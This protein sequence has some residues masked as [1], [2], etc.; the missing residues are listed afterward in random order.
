[1]WRELADG[2]AETWSYTGT[3]SNPVVTH[4]RGAGSRT[5][6][7]KGSQVQHTYNRTGHEVAHMESE[8]DGATQVTL[9]YWFGT[10]PDNSG[11]PTRFETMAIRPTTGTSSTPAAGLPAS[12]TATDQ[13]PPI[14]AMP[15]SASTR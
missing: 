7:T 15:L 12:A 13:P 5:G 9:G 1:M 6:V 3:V 14:R 2:T 11:R 8:F 10:A 4:R